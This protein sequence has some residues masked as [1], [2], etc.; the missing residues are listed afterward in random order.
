[1]YTLNSKIF[2]KVALFTFIL[3]LFSNSAYAIDI[4]QCGILNQAGATYVLKND[5]SSNNACFSIQADDITINLNSHTITYAMNPD[6]I[7]GEKKARYGISGMYCWDPDVYD[8]T[9]QA[10]G[11]LC[12]GPFSGLTVYGGSIVQGSNAGDF[13]HAIRLGQNAGDG[14]NIHDL[15]IYVASASSF[16]IFIQYPQGTRP[17]NIYNNLIHNNV[18]VIYNRHAVEGLSIR[19]A[20]QSSPPTPPAYIYNNIII[21]GAQGGIMTS[22]PNSKIYNNDISQ[23]GTFTND[24]SIYAWATGIEVYNNNVH[25]YGSGR[26]GRGIQIDYSTN[27]SVHDN[28]IQVW[29][30]NQND[31][32]GGCQGGGAYGIQFESTSYNALAYNNDVTAYADK[33]E[34]KGLRVTETPLN[35]GDIS[36]NNV[37]RGLRVGNTTASGAA[38]SFSGAENFTSENDVFV[39]D[40]VLIHTYWNGF[41]GVVLRNSTFLKGPNPS[42]NFYFISLVIGDNI[43]NQTTTITIEDPNFGPGVS[44]DSYNMRSTGLISDW[45]SQPVQYFIRWTFDLNVKDVNNNPI[46]GAS[47]TIKDKLSQQV[48]SGT[49]N[50]NGKISAMLTEFRRYND[51]NGIWKEMQ[52]PHTI[53]VSK[54]GYNALSY[55]VTMDSKKS[56]TVNL[57]T[58]AG[59]I[60]CSDGTQTNQCST[61]KPKFCNSTATLVDKCTT[62]GCLTGQ[63]CNS[64]TQTCYT[65]VQPPQTCSD[66]TAVNSCSSTKP[67]FCNSAAVL[68]DSCSTC[69]CPTNQ[70]CNAT[71]QTCYTP[72]QDNTPPIIS[73]I[74][75]SPSQTSATITWTTNENSNSTVKYGLT[76]T[77]LTSV[78]ASPSLVTA[79][80]I[81]FSGLAASTTYFYTLIS[82][83]AYGNCNTSTTQNFTTTPVPQQ[84]CSDG[85]AINVCSATKP[86]YCD[87]NRNLVDKC[88]ACGCATGY[89]CNTATE[90]CVQSTTSNVT[91]YNKLTFTGKIIKNNRNKTPCSFCTLTIGLLGVSNTT[92]TSSTGS[93]TL[94]LYT[95]ITPGT[96][97]LSITI[98]DGTRTYNFYKR[99]KIDS[100]A[101]KLGLKT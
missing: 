78:A 10:G 37:Y 27:F 47:V 90:V 63:N 21:G 89:T 45:T 76:Q 64:T 98:N 9:K 77:S 1:M 91:V 50:S 79:H 80:S 81:P 48:F 26:Y 99:I 38:A 2:S 8:T 100:T 52:T 95:T 73:N 97:T 19:V 14:I 74:V 92:T 72:Q 17:I 68:L 57:A 34:G 67:K 85:T 66:G 20:P 55:N 35:S 23:S 3:V 51:A 32:Y 22:L 36:R 75:A 46:S 28:K 58:G 82:C 87:A 5:V 101:E 40:S 54:S 44:K 43:N 88:T 31:E 15:T 13:S 4:T 6:V 61:T 41:Y 60:T 93:F 24:F 39:A 59:Q 96:Y 42:P 84:A 7:N 86:K 33:C 12:G 11:A 65:P 30:I 94:N 62:C 29:E 69:G 18:T 53:T 16:P 71:T 56:L 25:P 83:D 49:T 70:Q